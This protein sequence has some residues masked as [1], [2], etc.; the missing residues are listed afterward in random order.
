MDHRRIFT[1]ALYVPNRSMASKLSSHGKTG[2][3]SRIDQSLN[4]GEYI[5]GENSAEA[6]NM[7]IAGKTSTITRGNF[8]TMAYSIWHSKL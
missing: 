2:R 3:Y 6:G 4:L 8:I 5:N 7:A 1:L